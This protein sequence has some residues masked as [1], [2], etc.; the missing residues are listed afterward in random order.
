MADTRGTPGVGNERERQ[1]R[2]ERQVKKM[3]L[4]NSFS[5]N[6]LPSLSETVVF[7]QVAGRP[8]GVSIESHVGHKDLAAMLGVAHSRDSVCLARGERFL[9][10]Q[11]VGPRLPEGTTTLPPNAAIKWVV[12]DIY[13]APDPR[14]PSD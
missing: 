1:E 2:Q 12:G 8:K 13:E 7:N 4:L 10:A 11:Y 5:L 6:M 9:V 14:E 3:K